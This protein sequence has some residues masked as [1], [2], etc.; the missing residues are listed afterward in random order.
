MLTEQW[1]LILAFRKTDKVLGEWCA[2][3]SN[4]RS[5][6]VANVVQLAKLYRLGNDY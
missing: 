3:S 4:L 5:W 1:Q 2:I 6:I